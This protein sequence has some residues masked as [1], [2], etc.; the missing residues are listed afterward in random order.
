MGAWRILIVPLLAFCAP[1]AAAATPALR[2]FHASYSLTWNGMSAGSSE[3]QL[4]QLPEGR[5]AYQQRTAA[6][7]VFRLAM[8]GEVTSRSTFSVVEGR[9]VPQQF[10]TDDGASSNAKD[11]QV[12][13]DWARGRL[14]GVAERK[15]IDLP[16]Q[17]GLL[18][19][20]SVHIALRLEL[21]AGR[22]P[23]HFSLFDKDKIKHYNYTAEG[24]EV[25]RTE[26]GEHRTVIFRSNRPGSKKSTW[27]W[28]APDLDFMPVKVETRE[29]KNVE[30]SMAVKSL[31]FD[32]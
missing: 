32:P 10:I 5:W 11:Q 19:S 29:G 25:L 8:P 3:I 23:Q 15:P 14:T 12:T 16:A 6:R 24:S 22:T 27:F 9:V 28:C 2:P 17:P 30:L 20:M 13:F 18:D 4:Q 31:T 1:L 26:M 7:G 21:M